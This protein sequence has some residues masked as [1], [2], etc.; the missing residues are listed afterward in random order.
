M[1]NNF[2]SIVSFRYFNA[3]KNEKF[4]SIISGIS[5]AGITI[6]VAALIIVMSV[7]NGFHIELTNN[8]IGLNG[9][10]S[11]TPMGKVIENYEDLV[12]K[13]RNHKFVKK[14]TPLVVGQALALGTGTNSGVIIKGIDAVDLKTKGEILGNVLE[15]SF[16]DYDGANVVAVGSELAR[17]LGISAG[18]KIKL[19][20]PSLLSTAFGSMPR[21]KDFTVVAIFTSGLYDY[22]A[23][24]MLMPVV[25]AQKFLSMGNGINLLEINIEEQ[26]NA[27]QYSK[28]LQQDFGFSVQVKSWM[29]DNQQFLSALEVERVAMFAILSLIILVAA[30]NIIS[31]LFM[32]VKDK[33]KDIAILKTIGASTKQ[34]MLIFIFNGMMIGFIGTFL[35]VVFGLLFSYNIENVRQFLEKLSG[36]RI[37]DPAIYFLYSLPSVVRIS[38]VVMI[39]SIALVLSFLATIYP[40]YKASALSPIEAMRYE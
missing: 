22:D 8:I 23:A 16:S 20:A 36:T 34:I 6:G 18:S 30:F 24:A 37:F 40:A 5:L 31:S 9:D 25:A 33:T 3:K 39:T 7:M 11:V 28:T 35:G 26:E 4:V 27:K 1:L 29:Q 10:I 15:G 38:D 21:A 17:V 14:V 12:S 13:A 2:I 32:V 19:I